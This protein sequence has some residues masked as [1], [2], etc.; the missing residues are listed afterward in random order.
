MIKVIDDKQLYRE[1]V[2]VN[3][4]GSLWGEKSICRIH[5]ISIG[6]V[7]VCQ[8]WEK[9]SSAGYKDHDGQLALFDLEPALEVVQKVDEDL[10]NYHWMV[11]E[12]D[13]LVGYLNSVLTGGVGGG[14]GLTAQ[15]GI[16]ATLPKGKGL[17]LSELKIPEEKFEKQ[18]RRLQR[19]KQKVRSIDAAA[20]KITD[21][22]ERTVL[23]CILEGERMNM[24]AIRVGISRQRLN[25]IKREIV[26]RLAV[27]MYGDELKGA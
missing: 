16:E 3:C 13:R 23:E 18:V 14:G 5:D 1:T 17:K 19:L 9:V 25:E 8:E 20:E 21:E 10:K 22:K 4:P 2:C 15:Y 26:K 24:I 27:E 7:E 12:I 6:Q 11:K